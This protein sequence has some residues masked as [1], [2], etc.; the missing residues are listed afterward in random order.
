MRNDSGLRNDL[1]Y[2]NAQYVDSVYNMLWFSLLV[3]LVYHL[4]SPLVMFSRGFIIRLAF[5]TIAAQTGAELLGVGS[6]V[7]TFRVVMVYCTSSPI[8]AAQ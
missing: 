4:S 2:V 6:R 5:T 3:L 8:Q 1:I 7:I